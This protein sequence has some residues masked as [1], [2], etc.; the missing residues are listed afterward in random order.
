[1]IDRRTVLLG[2]G[3]ALALAACTGAAP[4]PAQIAAEAQQILG[5]LQTG[6]SIVADASAVVALIPTFAVGATVAM[7]GGEICALLP[8]PTTSTELSARMKADIAGNTYDAIV[9]H[10]VTIP[11]VPVGHQLA[12]VLTKGLPAVIIN[13]VSVAVRP[14]P[15]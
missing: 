15:F 12:P 8:K 5:W 11:Y 3:S 2:G 9:L 7:I 10:N 1:M 14:Y 4:T 6:C 13:G